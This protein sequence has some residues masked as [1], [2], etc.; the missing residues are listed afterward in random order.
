MHHFK[1]CS[2]PRFACTDLVSSRFLVDSS[3]AARLPFKMFDDVC[4]VRQFAIDPGFDQ[5]LVEKAPRG[6]DKRMARQILFITRLLADKHDA[7]QTN[8]AFAEYR[9]RRMLV[10]LAAHAATGRRLQCG[11]VD[12]VRKKIE[13]ASLG[14]VRHTFFTCMSDEQIPSQLN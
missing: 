3:L 11:V 14:Y 9:L 7:R 5:R 4:D 6:T 8:A 2:K 13:S 10:Q 12:L 1:F